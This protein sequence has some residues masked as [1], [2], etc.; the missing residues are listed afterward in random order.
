MKSRIRQQSISLHRKADIC[1]ILSIFSSFIGVVGG[2][3]ISLIFLN[4]FIFLGMLVGFG[5]LSFILMALAVIFNHKAFRR[6]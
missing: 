6:F 1:S 4:E 2:V 5:T 3:C